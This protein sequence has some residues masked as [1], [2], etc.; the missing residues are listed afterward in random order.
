MPAGM[1]SKSV[2]LCLK[3]KI[4]SVRFLQPSIL[5][6]IPE[7]EKLLKQRTKKLFKDCF[8]FLHKGKASLSDPICHYGIC[9]FG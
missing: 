8:S 7:R 2:S 3:K 9:S 6:L 4:T 1:Y 5:K